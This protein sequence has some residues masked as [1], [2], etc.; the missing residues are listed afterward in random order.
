MELNFNCITCNIN[1]VLRVMKIVDIDITIKEEMMREVLGYL[2]DIDYSKSNPEVMG[3]TWK[4]ILKY[5]SDADPY[6]AIKKEYNLEILKTS[7]EIETIIQ[8]SENKFNTALKIA[9]V[10]NLIDFAAKHKFDFEMLRQKILNVMNTDLAVDNSKQL[11][12]KLKKAKSVLYIGDNCGEICLDKLFIKYI[13]KDFPD[14]KVFFGVRGQAVIN[15]VTYD[16]AKM[17]GMHEVAE[18]VENGDGSLGTVLNRV[19]ENFKNIFY[20]ADIVIAKGQGNFESLSE[21]ERESIF[22]LLMAKCGPVA[23]MLGVEVM[24]I[25][26]AQNKN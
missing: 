7:D 9:I 6:S 20:S 8:N 22:Y 5:L 3:G 17:I 11:Y 21:E 15:D 26:C 4:I 12:D 24:S 13:K 2:K 23:N 18:I 25:V 14:I 19:S 10:G 16:D 1:Q